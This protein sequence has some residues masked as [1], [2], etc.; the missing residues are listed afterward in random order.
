MMK[1]TIALFLL[2]ALAFVMLPFTA[3]AYDEIYCS[4]VQIVGES[5]YG[6]RQVLHLFLHAGNGY[7]VG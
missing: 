4:V 3:A 7:S 1:K 6:W 2:L 5:D